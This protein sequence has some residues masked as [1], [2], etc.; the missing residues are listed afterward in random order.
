MPN[1]P[2]SLADRRFVPRIRQDSPARIEF[3]SAKKRNPVAYE[4]R[5]TALSSRGFTVVLPPSQGLEIPPIVDIEFPLDGVGTFRAT[6]SVRSSLMTARSEHL[7]GLQVVNVAEAHRLLLDQ[8]IN[9]QKLDRT[10][11]FDRRTAITVRSEHFEIRKASGQIIRG[12]KDQSAK[13][14]TPVMSVIIVPAFGETKVDGLSLSYLLASNGFRCYR[15]DAT[16]HIGESSGTVLDSTLSD[17][18][19]DVRA[20]IDFARHSGDE[21]IAV[22]AVGMAARVCIKLLNGPASIQHATLI[23]PIVSL[24]ATLER[25]YNE[26]VLAFAETENVGIVDLLGFPVSIRSFLADAKARKYDQPD[27]VVSDLSKLEVP[28]HWLSFKDD[29]RVP[30]DESVAALN[31]APAK[32]RTQSAVSSRTL[33]TG[34]VNLPTDVASTIAKRLLAFAWGR[35]DEETELILPDPREAALQRALE[36]EHLRT[37]ISSTSGPSDTE[38]WGRYLERFHFIIRVPEYRSFYEQIWSMVGDIQPGARLLDAGCGNGSLGLWLL[39]QEKFRSPAFD[40]D[41]LYAGL[42][43]VPQAVVQAMQGHK[44][45]LLQ[46]QHNGLKPQISFGYNV[47]D[48]STSLPYPNECFEHICCNLVLS[49]LPDPLFTLRELYRVLKPKGRM[50]VTTIKPDPDFS[51]IYRQTLKYCQTPEEQKGCR[52]L[53]NNVA[54]IVEQEKQGV[55]RFFTPQELSGMAE[56]AGRGKQE[57]ATSF[58][59]QAYVLMMEKETV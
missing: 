55:F 57:I 2:S 37:A 11:L 48:L 17:I 19:T 56:R 3:V 35:T 49:Y 16:N 36:R 14:G 20:C 58:G 46:L 26:D 40:R 39:L 33:V 44:E 52:R 29:T 32:V 27:D 8:F 6:C 4:A 45:L 47:G 38:F 53:L 25:I 5:L 28:I 43:L 31:A 22:I 15:Y 12:M 18:E 59:D 13:F 30:I 1:I 21:K 10:K 24:K 50:V 54:G 34:Y 42:D 9:R 23:G 51:L 7:L 41:L